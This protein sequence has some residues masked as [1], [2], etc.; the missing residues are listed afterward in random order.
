VQYSKKVQIGNMN[1]DSRGR[2]V[3]DV[4]REILA[5]LAENPGARDTLEGITHWWLLESGIRQ[6]AERVKLALDRLVEEGLVL[7]SPGHHS[8]AAYQVN[9]ERMDAIRLRLLQEL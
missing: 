5:Y 6:Q 3:A 9:P 8:G 7:E 4:C 1:R 2:S